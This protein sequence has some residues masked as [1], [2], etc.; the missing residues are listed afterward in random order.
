M[1]TIAIKDIKEDNVEEV[2]SRLKTRLPNLPGGLSSFECKNPNMLLL[3]VDRFQ[4]LYGTDGDLYL[5]WNTYGQVDGNKKY[6]KALLATC[7]AINR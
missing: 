3:W 7:D 1:T 4:G 2:F 5:E 6:K